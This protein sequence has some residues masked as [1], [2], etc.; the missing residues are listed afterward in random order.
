VLKKNQ[1]IRKNKDFKVIFN[2]GRFFQ[3]PFFLLKFKDNNLKKT[4]FGFVVS[5]KI[6]K[7]AV[8][9][10][11]IKRQ[12]RESVK[13]IQESVKNGL[14]VVFVAKKA[15]LHKETKDIKKRVLNAFKRSKILQ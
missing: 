8:D 5:L 7:K 15:I 1:R 14:D 12:L 10:N 2:E 9:R 3:D 4:R 6:S 11:R 13:S